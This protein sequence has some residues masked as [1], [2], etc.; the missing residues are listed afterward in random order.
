MDSILLSS[1]GQVI[2]P[3]HIRSD[4]HWEDTLRYSLPTQLKIVLFAH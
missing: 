2:I 4:Y 1:K 3:K